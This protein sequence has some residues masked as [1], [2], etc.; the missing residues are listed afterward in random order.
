M[1]TT[2]GVLSAGARRD[3]RRRLAALEGTEGCGT[4]AINLHSAAAMGS[5]RQHHV[6]RWRRRRPRR[7]WRR[8]RRPR[9]LNALGFGGQ[10]LDVVSLA[11]P[12]RKLR[13]WCP[14]AS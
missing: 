3:R 11:E 5:E 13:P 4:D 7:G 9:R 14:A 8:R 1:K 6:C 2:L 10:H 12:R